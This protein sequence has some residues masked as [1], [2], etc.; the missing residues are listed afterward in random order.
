MRHAKEDE[1][2]EDEVEVEVTLLQ[3]GRPAKE[4]VA[5]MPRRAADRMEEGGEDGIE[6]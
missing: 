4:V 1:R 6:D 2:N 3:R 5:R